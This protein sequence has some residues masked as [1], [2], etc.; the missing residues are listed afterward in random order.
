MYV[1]QGAGKNSLNTMKLLMLT[2]IGGKS[3]EGV[4]SVVQIYIFRNH[5]NGRVLNEEHFYTHFR[6]KLSAFI[7]RTVSQGRLLTH[8]NKCFV[9]LK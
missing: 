9:T 8:Q 5:A 7:Y 6:V 1:P 2:I 3:L 4:C